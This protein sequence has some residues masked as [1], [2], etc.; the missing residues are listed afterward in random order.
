[1]RELEFA[2]R[3][4]VRAGDLLL[5]RQGGRRD[6]RYKGAGSSNVVTE[7]D[8][9]SEEMIVRALRREFPGHAVVAEERG[10]QGDSPF[11]WHID[12]LDGTVNYAHGLPV[13]SVSVAYAAHGRVE[14]GAIY[15][16]T[17]GD[18]FWARRG[19]GAFRNRRP[20]RVSRTGRLA[21]ALLATGFPY[22]EPMRTRNLRYFGA[23]MTR[24]QALRRPGSA[25]LDLAWTACGAL[26]GYWEF[27]LGSWDIA[28]GLLIAAEA[29]ARITDFR[30]RPVD[31]A[32][33][34]IVAAN[35]RIH[36]QMLAV[37][38]GTRVY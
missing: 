5:R 10:A 7:M 9:A 37:I 25:S 17:F 31:L 15:A 6:I 24:A 18:L 33:G 2:R 12:P 8:H 23:F 22:Q 16:P 21:K 14:A 19:H 11:C 27:S 4:A 28:A 3:L 34:Q 29:G 20:I 36:R 26:D 1:M 32:V 13:W 35:P 38:R 30:G